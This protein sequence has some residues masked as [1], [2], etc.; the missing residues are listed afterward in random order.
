M[1]EGLCPAL[2]GVAAHVDVR[3]LSPSPMRSGAYPLEAEQ[4]PKNRVHNST[5]IVTACTGITV[6]TISER[7]CDSDFGTSINIG[8]YAYP[9]KKSTSPAPLP[10]HCAAT[11]CS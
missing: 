3:Q 8:G 1:H 4:S 11:S 9:Y 5:M 6:V 7:C 2:V 10:S